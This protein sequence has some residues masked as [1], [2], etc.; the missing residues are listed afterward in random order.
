MW[1]SILW[2]LIFGGLFYFMMRMGGCGMHSHGG[3]EN[4]GNTEHHKDSEKNKL[5]D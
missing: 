5:A 4:H 3:Y 1:E 2:F